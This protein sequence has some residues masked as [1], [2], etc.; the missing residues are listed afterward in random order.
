MKTLIITLLLVIPVLAQCPKSEF[1][2][3]D[4]EHKAEYFQK[5]LG[6]ALK[7]DYSP[8]QLALIAEVKDFIQPTTYDWVALGDNLI[9]AR[10]IRLEEKV[11]RTFKKSDLKL[12]AVQPD[13][14]IPQ[15]NCNIG[16]WF[17]W[18]CDR[19]PESNCAAL[20]DGCGFVGLYKC[21]GYCG[22]G[23]EQ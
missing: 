2:K 13:S 5:R 22:G 19:C 4:K 18:T 17:N 7:G 23:E 11:K 3:M 16:S 1:Q 6:T 9:S 14:F 10:A 12:F 21:D 8:V 20:P 15:C